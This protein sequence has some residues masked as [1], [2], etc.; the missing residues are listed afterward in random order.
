MGRGFESLCRYQK[1]KKARQSVVID[2][3]LFVLEVSDWRLKCEF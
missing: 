2:G 1:N 3:L